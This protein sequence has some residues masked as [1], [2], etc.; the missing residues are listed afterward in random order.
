MPSA[1]KRK[2]SEHVYNIDTANPHPRLPI[3]L[4]VDT[5]SSMLGHPIRELNSGMR[6][7]YKSLSRNNETKYTADIA[8]VTFGCDGVRCIQEFAQIYEGI[9]PPKLEADGMT[10]M[11]EAVNLSLDLIEQR[12]RNYLE[13]NIRHYHSML[14]IMADGKTKGNSDELIRAAERVRNFENQNK[15]FVIAIGVGNEADMHA[16]SQFS[17]KVEPVKLKGLNFMSFFKW[18]IVSVEETAAGSPENGNGLYIK[19]QADSLADW[20]D[21]SWNDF[22]Q[23]KYK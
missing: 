5:S 4:C 19:Q 3:C 14:I 13:L 16:L 7:F 12:R 20:I 8:V 15:L 6:H 17:T 11:G 22:R 18:L 9:S 10:P 23:N 21:G 1:K 2:L